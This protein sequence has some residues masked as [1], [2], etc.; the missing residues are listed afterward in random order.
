ME[1][2][3]EVCEIIEMWLKEYWPHGMFDPNFVYE[4]VGFIRCPCISFQWYALARVEDFKIFIINQ[5]PNGPTDAKM[6]FIHNF[7]EFN[8]LPKYLDEVHS[9]HRD[10]KKLKRK[11]HG[12]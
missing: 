7:E 5:D 11:K 4:R 10:V 9:L 8:K 6:I 12:K 2:K 3:T 1:I